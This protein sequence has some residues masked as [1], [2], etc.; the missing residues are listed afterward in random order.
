MRLRLDVDHGRV[1]AEDP[2]EVGDDRGLVRREL[3]PLEDD[4]AVEVAQGVSGLVHEAD[5]VVFFVLEEGEREGQR[6]RKRERRGVSKGD[7][8]K[9]ANEEGVNSKRKKKDSPPP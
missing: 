6:K 7:R 2:A 4:G 3:G 8:R 5:L 1:R 9:K